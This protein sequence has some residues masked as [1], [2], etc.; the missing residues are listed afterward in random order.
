MTHLRQRMIEDMG[1]R[2]LADNT[3]S[4]YLQQVIAYAEHFHRSP[5]ELGPEAVRAYQ[6]YL[7]NTRGLSPSSISVATGALRFLYKVTLKRDWA[8]DEIPMPKRWSE[9][10][11]LPRLRTGI[12]GNAPWVDLIFKPGERGANPF[13]ALAF[14]LKTGLNIAGQTEHEIARAIE[15]DAH[16]AEKHLTQLLLK[17]PQ[18][19]EL[20]LVVDQFEELFTQCTADHR[21]HFLALLEHL[22]TLPRI[23]CIAT[24]RA[25]FYA[26]A[27]EESTL[28][29]LLRQDRGTFPLDPPDMSAIL[30]MIIRP[31]EAAGVELEDG[32]AQRLLKDAGDG[33]GAMALIAFTLEQLYQRE[34][35]SRYLSIKAYENAGGVKGAIQNRA[36]FALKGLPVN[37]DSALPILFTNLIEVNE[38]EVATRRRAPLSLLQDD[39][40]TVADALT[41]ARLLVTG[42]GADDQ[43][44]IEVAHE[45]ILSS[46]EPLHAMDTYSRRG[47]ARPP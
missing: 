41:E 22:V 30:Q 43:P 17:Y 3:Q 29:N 1:I 10:G 36:E 11:L 27:I 42:K 35:S 26:R 25:D 5:E 32:L 4:A 47:P 13:M 44:M 9:A 19:G 38:Q 45:T 16:V 14:A 34:Q 33:P 18:A 28:A 21:Q 37:V 7:T 46:W 2:N 8:V 23:R 31:A 39:V 12:I 24:L 15:T 6:L 20:L 40:K